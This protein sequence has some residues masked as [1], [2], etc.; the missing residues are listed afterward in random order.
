MEVYRKM[1]LQYDIFEHVVPARVYY[2]LPL[3]FHGPYEVISRCDA[4]YYSLL[5][6]NAKVL[7][8]PKVFKYHQT[9]ANMDIT[10]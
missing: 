5:Q 4:K 6:Y 10:E 2:G 3:I 8:T 9:V 7:V 1:R